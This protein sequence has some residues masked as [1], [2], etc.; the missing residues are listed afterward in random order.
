MVTTDMAGPGAVIVGGAHVSLGIARSLG[1]RG[2][3]V[4]LL[5][6]HPLPKFSRYVKRSFD[7]CG[8][9]HPDGLQQILNVGVK[10]D[11]QGWVLIPTG[12]QDLRLIAQN[13]A[14]LSGM[15]RV[16]AADWECVQWAYDKRMTHRR[17]HSLGIDVPWSFEPQN[18]DDVRALDCRF[19]V[20]LKPAYRKGV[21]AFTL[22]KAWKAENRDMLISLYR[23]ASSLVGA[24]A[25]IVQEWIPGAGSTQFSCA[26]LWERGEPLALL[27]ARRSRQ[28]PIDFGR[29]STFV[30]TIVQEDVEEIACRFMRSLAY[31]GVAEVEFKYDA[32]ERR[33]NLLDVN[34]RFWTWCGVGARAGVD[35]PH[36]GYLQAL[37]RTF[38]TG[39]ARAGVAWMH[40]RSD[41]K[42]AWEEM[43]R[44]SLSLR[45]YLAGLRQPLTFANFAVDDPLP[46]L[47]E[48][49]AA[50]LNRLPLRKNAATLSPARGRLRAAK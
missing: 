11:L 48:V 17:A 40:P 13:R 38:G 2:I 10:H 14:Q 32:R 18:L 16:A 29:S 9:D 27:T 7:W 22:A 42:A 36:L 24:D 37:G 6:N 19:P 50:L 12:D 5:A 43:R 3:P 8:A 23:E 1:R 33:F 49:P 47:M 20:I 4:W 39:R 25:V 15:F 21:D 34:A 35:F 45:S 30:E 31:T 28:H 41:V 44:G 26:G 46:A